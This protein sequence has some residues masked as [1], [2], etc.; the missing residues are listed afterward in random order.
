[1]D[2]SNVSL[3]G[4]A[5]V[6]LTLRKIEQLQMDGHEIWNIPR[7]VGH[8]IAELIQAHSAKSVLEIGTSSGYSGIFIANALQQ[9]GGHLYTIESHQGRF[10]LAKEHFAQ[11]GFSDSITQIFG[12]APEVFIPDD[13]KPASLR[14]QSTGQLHPHNRFHPVFTNLTFDFV[15]LDATKREHIRHFQAIEPLLRPNAI[16]LTDNVISHKESMHDY[17]EY[18]MA[19]PEFESEL[20]E[21][22]TGILKSIKL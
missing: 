9:T 19:H 4:S 17:H 6:Q 14:R 1:M 22:G 8:F 18:V 7:E 10:S 13:Q 21:I 12:H 16:I 11:A 15:F 2:K 3:P 20:I 5:A